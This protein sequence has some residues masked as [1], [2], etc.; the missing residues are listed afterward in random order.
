MPKK[1]HPQDIEDRRR[2]A[3]EADSF[4]VFLRRGPFE[5]ISRPAPTM[6]EAL[7]IYDEVKRETGRTPLLYAVC[8]GDSIMVPSDVISAAR[9]A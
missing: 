7:A 8:S 6:E 4:N 1:M 9:G 3:E 5:K 2:I